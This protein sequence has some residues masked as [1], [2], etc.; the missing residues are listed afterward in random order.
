[1]KKLLVVLAGALA[2]VPSALAAKPVPSLTPAATKKLWRAEVARVKQHPRVLADASC[3]PARIVFYA[4]TDWLRLTTKL[5]QTPS[6]CAQYYVSVPPL[7]ADKSQARPNQASQ[8]R[9][10]GPQFHALDEISWNGWSSWVSANASTWYQA[11]V[12]ARQRMTA[13][14]FDTGAGDTWA[15][16]ELSSAVRLGTGSARRNALDFMHGLSSDGVKG[17]VFVAGIGQS[18]SD[19]GPYKV[20]LQNW[21]QDSAFWTEAA[22]Y[23]S[24]WAQEDYG[25]IRNYAV[26]GATPQARRDVE[27]QYLGHELA[28]ANAGP[29]TV[30]AARALLQSSYVAFGNAAWA[31]SSAYGYT[32]GSSATMQD[33]VS[34]QIY[35]ARSIGAPYAVDR[36]GFAWAPS[37]TQGLTTADFNAQSAAVLDRI[38]AGIRDSGTPADDPGAAACAPAWCTTAVDGAAF[39]P[40]WQGFS[41]WSGTALAVNSAPATFTAG[42]SM[43]VSVQIQTAGVPQNATSDQTVTFASTSGSGAFSTSST[44]PWTPTLSVTIPTGTSSASVFY[45]DTLAGSPSISASLAGQPAVAQTESVTAGPV[46]QLSVTPASANVVY[47]RSVKLTAT[48]SDAYG[49]VVTPA[50][51]WT[52]SSTAYGKLSSAGSAATFTAASRTGAVTVT[53]SSGGVSTTAR[54]SIVRR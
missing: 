27:V 9:A 36:F 12:T 48:A 45:T 24:D 23:A 49:N 51:A 17:T 38:G 10:L 42:S 1:M 33:F 14:G 15:L 44:G 20:N 21:L 8:I 35:A 16:N 3:R 22:G 19:T 53:A 4:Q 32:N 6:P 30:A 39:T 37:N 26:G 18:T 11:G 41:T 25:D 13:A 52:L 5:A 7:A 50:P 46:A 40:A 43:P 31:W 34:G 47:G 29:D 28:L 2:I 54:L